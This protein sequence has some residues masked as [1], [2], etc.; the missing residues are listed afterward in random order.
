[1]REG[2][3]V[4]HI[5]RER[6]TPL[7]RGGVYVDALIL[8]WVESVS[9]VQIREILQQKESTKEKTT[10]TTGLEFKPTVTTVGTKYQLTESLYTELSDLV[11]SS[12]KSWYCKR[13][14]Q[15]GSDRVLVLASQARNDGKE[16]RR[17][18]SSLLKRG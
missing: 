12:F 10:V 9:Q 11:N 4:S 16:P 13:F 5:K 7:G 2:T 15:L 6:K 17:L 18:F 1:M 8:L 3:L 14:H